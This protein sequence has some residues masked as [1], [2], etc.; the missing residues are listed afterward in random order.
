ML[1]L[2][3]HSISTTQVTNC[4]KDSGKYCLGFSASFNV[5]AASIV[6]HVRL[7]SFILASLVP[8]SQSTPLL[9]FSFHTVRYFLS[10]AVTFLPTWILGSIISVLL[11]WWGFLQETF[12][13]PKSILL[14]VGVSYPCRMSPQVLY[15][16]AAKKQKKGLKWKLLFLFFNWGW[17]RNKGECYV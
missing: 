7:V 16:Y 12:S 6:K 5:A 13:D 11:L 1:C 15:I 2:R 14:H 8:R 10:S 17:G 9:F 3:S 4:Y